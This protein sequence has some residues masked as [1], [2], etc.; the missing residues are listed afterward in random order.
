MLSDIRKDWREDVQNA[1]IRARKRLNEEY[2][3][4]TVRATHGKYHGRDGAERVPEA[5]VTV[6]EVHVV[7]EGE[8]GER[9]NIAL[10][11]EESDGRP[12]DEQLL[13]GDTETILYDVEDIEVL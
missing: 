13:D 4:E 6:K 5:V 10:E 12:M 3:G 1:Y 9:M 7:D 2:A 8:R 11:T